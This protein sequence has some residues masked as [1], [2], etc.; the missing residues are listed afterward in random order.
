ML[1]EAFLNRMIFSGMLPSE[2]E[3]PHFVGPAEY[4]EDHEPFDPNCEYEECKLQALAYLKSVY[5][6][7]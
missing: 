4:L 6:S 1:A 3:R 5:D 7:Q 2:D